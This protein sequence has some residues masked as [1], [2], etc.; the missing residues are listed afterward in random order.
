MTD[1]KKDFPLL[2]ERTVNG[3]S[4]AY[5]DN[6]ATSQKPKAVLEAMER[7]YKNFTANPHRGA[8]TISAEATAAYEAARERA[9]R[10]VNAKSADEIV[11]TAGTTEG[12]NLVALSYGPLKVKEGDEILITVA[13]HHSN[14]LPWQ[15]LAQRQGAKL[16]YL[17]P[18]QNGRLSMDEVREKINPRTKIVALC[19]ISNVLGMVNPVREIAALAHEVGAAVLVDAAQ[20]APHIR[21]DVQALDA[22]FLALSGHKMLGPAG[23]G[24]L[25]GKKELLDTMEPLMLGGGI[26][27]DVSQQSVRLLDAPTRFEAGTPYVEGAIGLAAAMDYLDSVGFDTI[28]DIQVELTG[29]TLE[30]MRA[31]PELTIY[32]DSTSTDRTGIIAFNVEGAHPHDTASILDAYA[33]A[34]RAGHH[35]AQPLMAHL[36]VSSTCRM[37]LYLYNTKEDIDRFIEA[38][39]K[40]REVLGLGAK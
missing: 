19:H 26:V 8:Y 29:Y 31:L 17:F 36:G 37:S 22:D 6:A 16:C 2:A 34:V 15:R 13:E 1:L 23:I 28:H 18:D 3:L 10:F 30:K 14:L 39:P 24:V 9:A 11:F 4:L 38:I 33:V 7:Y 12:I 25:Y 20:S 27:E 21:L 35:C 40:V 5:L 32:G